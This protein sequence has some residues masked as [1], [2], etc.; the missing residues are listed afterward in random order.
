MDA[1][2]NRTDIVH[3][4]Q[5]NSLVRKGIKMVVVF[6]NQLK[7]TDEI[8]NLMFFTFYLNRMTTG[9]NQNLR[10]IR[11]NQLHF[12][13]SDAIK[14]CGFYPFKLKTMFDHI[15]LFSY[16]KINT[17]FGIDV[18]LERHRRALF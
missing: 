4:N 1:L 14:F 11:F 6:D 12:G 17:F 9:N 2:I 10:A 8:T 13:I 18:N 7:F 15:C 5:M 16:Y 3:H